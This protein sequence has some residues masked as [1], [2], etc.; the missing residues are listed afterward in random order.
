MRISHPSL[1]DSLILLD[2]YYRMKKTNYVIYFI[3]KQKIKIYASIY[4][5][6]PDAHRNRFLLPMIYRSA[7][8][9]LN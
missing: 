1:H 2:W 6:A 3:F 4:P 7:L 8:K 9:F 5:S